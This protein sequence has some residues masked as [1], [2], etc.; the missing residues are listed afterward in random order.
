MSQMRPLDIYGFAP[1]GGISQTINSIKPSLT[2]F[3]KHVSPMTSVT[4]A[5]PSFF[6]CYRICCPL[7]YLRDILHYYPISLKLLCVSFLLKCLFLFI[8]SIFYAVTKK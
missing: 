4:K 2:L 7:C 1:L 8:R 6:V 3:L 5:L